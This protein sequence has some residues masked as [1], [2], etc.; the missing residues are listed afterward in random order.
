MKI[1]L[2]AFIVVIIGLLT[3]YLKAH[4]FQEK[5]TKEPEKTIRAT[6]ASKEVKPGTHRSGR[7]KGG[8]SYT[9]TF[10]TEDGQT[11]ELFAYE[12]EFGGLAEGTQGFLT[13]QG[14]YFVRF[15]DK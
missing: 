10:V 15:E 1:A 8:Y 9:I 5:P 3:A 6:V 13:Y 14:R 7:S 12:I 4:F 2:T 11:L